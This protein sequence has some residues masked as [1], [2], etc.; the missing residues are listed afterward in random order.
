MGATLTVELREDQRLDAEFLREGVRGASWAEAGLGKTR[1]LLAAAHGKTTVVCPAAI[2]DFDVWPNEAAKIGKEPPTVVSYHEMAKL[3]DFSEIA[4]DTLILDESQHVKNR[5]VSWS[6]PIRAFADQTEHVYEGTGSPMP[7]N[8]VEIWNQWHIM[9]GRTE[10]D[11]EYFWPWA[12]QYFEVGPTRYAKV[13]VGEYLIDCRHKPDPLAMIPLGCEHWD[14]FHEANIRGRASLRLRDDVLKDMPPLT[15]LD[16]PLWVGMT[17]L[18][19]RVYRGLKKDLLSIIP[20]EGIFLEALTETGAFIKMLQLTSGL[21]VLDPEADPKDAQSGKFPAVVEALSDSRR[22]IVLA[23][24]YGGTAKA[25]ARICD[26]MKLTHVTIGKRET[27]GQSRADAR[28]QFVTGGAN[29]LIGSI[30][31]IKE[32]LDGLQDV[33][34]EIVMVERSDVPGINDQVVRRLHR[35]GQTRPVTCRQLVCRASVD[36]KQWDRLADKR[37]RVGMA[38]SR[39]RVESML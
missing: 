35:M 1:L 23:C 3:T 33:S 18:Q 37:G 11:Y 34:D 4:C 13:A 15:G 20:D 5:K 2:R 14:A 10:R 24:W 21:S 32:G 12:R 38:L 7:N 19:Q 28:R 27:G 30:A 6:A 17:P 8:P 39:A 16:E 9:Y 29:V 25:L 36:S 31:V 26:R 22:P